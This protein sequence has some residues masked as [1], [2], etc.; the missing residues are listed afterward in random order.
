[1]ICIKPFYDTV[2]ATFTYVV[3]KPN[4]DTIIIDP[5]LDYEPTSGSISFASI[6]RVVDYIESENLSAK[7]ILDTHAHADHLTGA[8][9][10]AQKLGIKSAIGK[11]F[12]GVQRHFAPI[13]GFESHHDEL[14]MAY[15]YLIEDNE[16]LNAGAL[17]IKA[18]KVPGHTKSCMA[19]LIEDSL[20]CGDALFQPERGAGRADFPGASAKS[21]YDSIINRIYSLPPNTRIFVGHDYPKAGEDACCETSVLESKTKNILINEKTSQEQFIKEREKRDQSLLAP[22]LLFPSMQVNILGGRLPP[23]DHNGRFFIKVPISL[24][25]VP[26]FLWKQPEKKKV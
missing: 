9:F 5:V 11:D 13:F 18:L 12:I 23:R 7:L 22:R 8:Y 20:F 1:M 17:N 3:S 19:Y 14:S 15:D 4:K 6:Q 2:T 16:F 10:L 21:L 25:E 26:K 24:P